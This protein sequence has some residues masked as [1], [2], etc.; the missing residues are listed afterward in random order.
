MVELAA[1]RLE[2]RGKG[3]LVLALEHRFYGPS[4]PTPGGLQSWREYFNTPQAVAD[5][6]VFHD[7]IATAA[8]GNADAK[9]VT[10]GGS[11]PVSLQRSKRERDSV[12]VRE[13][14][15]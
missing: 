13:S 5:I 11:Y 3:T 14:S 7:H 2:Q 12:I 6:A 4:T 1:Q 8:S 10:F 9:W 15:N